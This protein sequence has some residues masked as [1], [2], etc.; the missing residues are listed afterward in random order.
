MK[1]QII[2]P[3]NN[4]ENMYFETDSLSETLAMTKFSNDIIHI[5]IVDDD[6]Q[7]RNLMVDALGIKNYMVETAKN[8]ETA[9]QMI[10]KARYSLIIIDINLPGMKGEKLLK[11]CHKKAPQSAIIMITG[12]PDLKVAVDLM[13][14]GALDYLA[15]P[16]EPEKLYTHINNVLK[17]RMQMQVNPLISPLLKTI[18]SEYNIIKTICST[19]TS[20]VL[21]VERDEKNY[22]MKIL[23]YETID[24]STKKKIKRFFREAQLMR[25]I[26]HPNIVKVYEYCF[27]KNHY[28]FI[29]TE[30][31]PNTSLNEK[32][33]AAMSL[34]EK[35]Y[36]TYKLAGAIWEVHKRGII[37]RDIKPSNIMVTKDGEPKLTDFGIAGIKDSAL[38][39]TTEIMGSPRYMSPESF[40]AT[41]SVDARSDIFS[42]GL[43]A[44]EIFTGRRAFTGNNINQII[45]EVS[46]NKPIKPTISNPELPAALDTILARMLA[47]EPD[48]R[49]K[50]I[51]ETAMDLDLVIHGKAPRKTNTFINRILSKLKNA[52]TVSTWN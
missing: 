46:N 43:V 49:Y 28:P 47:K 16:I 34:D 1:T 22:A 41:H 13:K 29:I 14:N 45:D 19:E 51:A 9:I 44:Y 26:S 33:T 5:L 23:K 11:Y 20:I 52:T 48:N 35:L 21:L 38:T 37:H 15:K 27:D 6:E 36:F 25:A 7:F 18:P 39:F 12:A 50:N 31:I 42:L 40:I 24:D 2:P 17:K 32:I 8:A 4:V 3:L 10:T 30:Y